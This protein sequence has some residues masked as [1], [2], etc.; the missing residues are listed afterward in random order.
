M[1]A[2]LKE[3]NIRGFVLRVQ[4]VKNEDVVA[5]V[6]SR[7]CVGRFYRFYGARHSILQLGYLIDFELE[8]DGV[9]LPRMR[10]LSHFSFPWIFDNARM[11]VWQN[12][13]QRF[14]MHFRDTDEIEPFYFELLLRGA[15]RWH[16][17]NPKRAAIEMYVEM[18]AYEGRLYSDPVCY[19]CETPISDEVAVM[20]GFKPAHAHCIYA[21]SIPWKVLKTLFKTRKTTF[22]SDTQVDVLFETMMK[23]F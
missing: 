4:R 20:G 2:E 3:A 21:S 12:L 17:Q 1:Y 16:R 18:L 9:H 8:E 10:A 14:E 19:M 7:E 6:L 5:T 13:M 22:L 23:A 11:M 15:K